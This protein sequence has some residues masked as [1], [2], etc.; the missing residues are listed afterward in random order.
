MSRRGLVVWHRHLLLAALA[1]G[2]AGANVARAASL[3]VALAA[4]ALAGAA[5]LLTSRTGRFALLAAALALAGWWWGSVRL[6]ALDRSSLAPEIGRAA[7]ALVIVTGPSRRG[8]FA[9]RVPAEVRRFGPLALRERVLLQ[10]PLGR[11]PPQ[12]AELD[13][14]GQLKAPRS[15]SDGFDERAWLRRQGIHAVL[16]ADRWTIVGRRGGLGG[17]ADR[18]RAALASSVARGLT[19]ERRGVLMGV[20]L[21]EDTALSDELR[22]AFRASGL[23]HLL[24]VSGQNVA[25][26]GGAAL[27][28][29]GLARLPRWLGHAIA[30]VAIGA[31]VLAVGAQPSVIRAGIAGALASIAWLLARERDRWYFLLLGAFALLAWNPYVVLDPGFQLSFAAVA[32][33]FVLAPRLRSRLEGYPIPRPVAL[34]VAISVAC[35]VAT[36]PI[37]WFHFHAVPVLSVPANVLAAP[38]MV[39]LL[40]LA[41]ATAA[42]DPLAPSAAAALA[43][44][45]GCCAAYVVACARAVAAVPFAQVTSGAAVLALGLVTA[46][47]VASSRLPPY[48]RRRL[49]ALGAVVAVALV[50]WRA[51][52]DPVLPPTN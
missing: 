29:V 28:L 8:T 13:L 48:R 4:P 15:A 32:A 33:I 24:A 3:G 19:G 30:V 27:L 50:G 46:A 20:V 1:C 21:G 10:L 2:I 43:W 34:V 7:R 52:P 38:A 14:V 47:V 40:G 35:G 51:R 26:V 18:F 37:L 31:Y 22:D 12:G 16:Q 5:V 41:F 11:A 39:P 44:L 23:Y 49:L 36:A 9:L 42:V 45:N 25:F 17:A 6:G